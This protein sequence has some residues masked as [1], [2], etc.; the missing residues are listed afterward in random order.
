MDEAA[1]RHGR[2]N[3]IREAGSI[4]PAAWAGHEPK[5]TVTAGGARASFHPCT[6]LL[7]QTIR[8][9]DC[10]ARRPVVILAY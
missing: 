2:S 7:Q 1:G 3:G 4:A 8:I 5:V 6:G 9:F 10:Q